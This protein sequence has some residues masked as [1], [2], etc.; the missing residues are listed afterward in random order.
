MDNMGRRFSMRAVEKRGRRDVVA[1][2]A[3]ELTRAGFG[4]D[5]PPS[6]LIL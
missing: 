3:S 6:L 5:V 2:A 4:V 1:L